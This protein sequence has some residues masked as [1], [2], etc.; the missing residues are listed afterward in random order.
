MKDHRLTSLLSGYRTGTIARQ[1]LIREIS[2]FV[3]SYPYKACRWKE[4]ICSEF[5]CYFY[6][7]IEKMIE[8][9]ELRGIPFEAYLVKCL[10]MQL[11]TFAAQ[12][13]AGLIS[14]YM[15]RNIIFWPFWE[16]NYKLMQRK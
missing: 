4:D 5:F 6:P 3:Y 8:S 16:Q 12:Q 11:K 1:L 15:Q 9:F 7:K 14:L 13:K 10:K 2:L